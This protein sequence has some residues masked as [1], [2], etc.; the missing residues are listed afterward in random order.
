M[1]DFTYATMNFKGIDRTGVGYIASISSY[2]PSWNLEFQLAKPAELC[3]GLL[4][5]SPYLFALNGSIPKAYPY[6][7]SIRLARAPRPKCE[8]CLNYPVDPS[9]PIADQCPT[10]STLTPQ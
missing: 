2:P 4:Y 8:V 10:P 7:D 5:T 9:S 3:E 1:P 6:P